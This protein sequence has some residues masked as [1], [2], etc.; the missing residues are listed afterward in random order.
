[1]TTVVPRYSAS[2]VG[3]TAR[4]EITL[5]NLQ[6]GLVLAPSTSASSAEICNLES[7]ARE[8]YGIVNVTAQL[9]SIPLTCGFDGKGVARFNRNEALIVCSYTGQSLPATL[10]GANYEAPL[11]VTLQYY[12]IERMTQQIEV[13]R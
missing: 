7:L 9:S 13:I 4:Y 1:V 6:N 10:A 5:R 8:E 12:Y 2:G 11:I 3:V